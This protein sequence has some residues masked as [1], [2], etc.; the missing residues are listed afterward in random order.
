MAYSARK[1]GEYSGSVISNSDSAKAG[2]AVETTVFTAYRDLSLELLGIYVNLVTSV[3]AGNRYVI[4]KVYDRYDNLKGRA[5][6]QVQAA[7]LTYYHVFA[8]T[9][10]TSYLNGT[11]AHNP[12]PTKVLQ[13]GEKLTVVIGGGFVGDVW[14]F[15]ASAR[16]VK[17]STNV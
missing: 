2:N 3:D 14:A 15:H 13:P 12:L 8:D 17:V 5:V 7:S 10:T 16:K 9:I 1:R 4:L 6:S 11:T